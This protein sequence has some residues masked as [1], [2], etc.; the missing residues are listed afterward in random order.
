MRQFPVRRRTCLAA[1]APD[2][3]VVHLCHGVARAV[4]GV[5]THFSLPG[6]AP[7]CLN[8]RVQP[9]MD[10]A[11]PLPSFCWSTD[12]EDVE[13]P[14]HVVVHAFVAEVALALRMGVPELAVAYGALE[15]IARL[16]SSALQ[17]FTTRPAWV[18]CCCLAVLHCSDACI[19]TIR[20]HR[21]LRD[22]LTGL[23]HDALKR[24][25]MCAYELME[26]KLPPGRVCCTG[27]D[28]HP[29]DGAIDYQECVQKLALVANMHAPVTARAPP[30][31]YAA[32]RDVL[33]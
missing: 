29:V 32:A 6:P 8:E 18:A 7:C 27:T 14:K 13:F 2:C 9:L 4:W 1:Q 20:L 16:N 5:V 21:M 3:E 15:R 10:V 33:W 28:A 22:L 23:D 19:T 25:I 24:A 17:P 11:S 31:C 12:F 30:D 26:W